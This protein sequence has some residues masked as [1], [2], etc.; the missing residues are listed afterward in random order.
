[1]P[2]H[3][4]NECIHSPSILGSENEALKSAEEVLVKRM[5][6]CFPRID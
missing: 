3:F 4:M 6:P 1:M 2:I 5:I